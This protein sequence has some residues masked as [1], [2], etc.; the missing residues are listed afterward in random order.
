MYKATHK[1]TRS[2]L[3]KKMKRAKTTKHTNFMT[4][5]LS[6]KI[7]E[8]LANSLSNIRFT[9]FPSQATQAKEENKES[10]PNLM[11]KILLR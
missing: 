11:W 6:G 3:R 9:I 2:N 10:Q 7:V 1:I 4:K 8:P 5:I